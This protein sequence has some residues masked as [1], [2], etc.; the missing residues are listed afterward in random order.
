MKTRCFKLFNTSFLVLT[1]HLFSIPRVT[2][3]LHIGVSASFDLTL[4][5]WPFFNTLTNYK[6]FLSR[7]LPLLQ[8]V[9]KGIA[10][11]DN[12]YIPFLLLCLSGLEKLKHPKYVKISKQM[13]NKE[14]RI[15]KYRFSWNELIVFRS[16]DATGCP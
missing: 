11:I 12:Y 8:P 1:F 15:V 7:V 3:H 10:L 2:L 16:E 4:K 13:C 14:V 5:L 6:S 9:K